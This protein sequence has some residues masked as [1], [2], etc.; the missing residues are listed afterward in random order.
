MASRQTCNIYIMA[1][2]RQSIRFS[3]ENTI[4]YAE[5]VVTRNI[6]ELVR[7]HEE[8]KQIRADSPRRQLITS[9][10]IQHYK[11]RTLHKYITEEPQPRDHINQNGFYS[12]D[13]TLS[14]WKSVTDQSGVVHTTFVVHV[15]AVT[16]AAHLLPM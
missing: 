4:L 2:K 13:I 1:A 9:S 5:K 6:I 16:Y 11:Q 15:Y 12:S 10:T 8:Y 3:I 7:E 14:I